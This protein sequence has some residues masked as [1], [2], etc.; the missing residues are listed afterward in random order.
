MLGHLLGVKPTEVSIEHLCA[1]C[2]ATDHG[3]PLL[4]VRGEYAAQR[5]S[6]S[7]TPHWLA[8]AMTDGENP[9]QRVGV[10]VETVKRVAR[11]DV[12]EIAFSPNEARV[13]SELD[14]HEKA[15]AA[16]QLW[17]AKEAVTKMMGVGLRADLTAIECSV[18]GPVVNECVV[19]HP[20]GDAHVQFHS[21]HQGVLA[22]VA[23]ALSEPVVWLSW[24]S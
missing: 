7:R 21:P 12:Q 8:V 15:P 19:M 14:E 17:T 20:G 16:T 4:L 6:I 18:V 24:G 2:G 1:N 3:Q 11:H 22:A 13:I 10:D 5:I 23:T 9:A